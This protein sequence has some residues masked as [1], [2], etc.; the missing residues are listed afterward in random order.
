MTKSNALYFT[1]VAERALVYGLIEEDGVH[2]AHA[3]G[4]S[5]VDLLTREGR[6]RIEVRVFDLGGDE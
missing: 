3:S 1:R 5:G 2:S 6:Y 4:D